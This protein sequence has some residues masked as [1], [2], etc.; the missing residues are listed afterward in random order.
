MNTLL[1]TY[2]HKDTP[3]HLG[4]TGWTTLTWSIDLR[5]KEQD[6]SVLS[7]DY[8]TLH[9][10]R[11][12]WHPADRYPPRRAGLGWFHQTLI[13]ARHLSDCTQES[14]H[15]C[16][17][18]QS[19]AVEALDSFSQRSF[20]SHISECA[21]LTGHVHDGYDRTL[22]WRERYWIELPGEDMNSPKEA[23][24]SKAALMSEFAQRGDGN[25]A[26][27]TVVTDVVSPGVAKA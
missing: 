24:F 26:D 13:I 11:K 23:E 10:L 5:T 15:F 25:N 16:V 6:P 7:V 18:P 3:A 1:C 17:G 14:R 20:V 19:R 4:P 22:L 21:V 27:A 9:L 8:C 2:L 12:S